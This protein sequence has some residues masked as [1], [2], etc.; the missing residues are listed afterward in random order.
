ME[1]AD[2]LGDRIGIMAFGRLRC[3]GNALHLK[4]KYGVG[5]RLGIVTVSQNSE[6]VKVFASRLTV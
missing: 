1:E 5:Y 4:S 2:T 6:E 3:I